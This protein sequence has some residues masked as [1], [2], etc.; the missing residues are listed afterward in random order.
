MFT[1][2][3]SMWGKWA[4]PA[5]WSYAQIAFCTVFLT[6][7]TN[8]Q[9]TAWAQL[10]SRDHRENKMSL[11]TAQKLFFYLSQLH[12]QQQT[13]RCKSAWGFTKI[14]R[15]FS[16][17][18]WVHHVLSRCTFR[19]VIVLAEDCSGQPKVKVYSAACLAPAN[20]I[21]PGFSCRLPQQSHTYSF[22]VSSS[23]T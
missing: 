23:L 7:L 15:A 22:S 16:P 21:K 19:K 8:G 2:P 13:W 9:C 6:V 11:G 18:M 17:V 3:R 12:A 10:R 20:L 14:I 1:I 5:P 4:I